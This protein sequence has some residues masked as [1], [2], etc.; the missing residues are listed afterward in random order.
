LKN[1]ENH[2]KVYL[3]Q[4]AFEYMLIYFTFQGDDLLGSYPKIFEEWFD[5][6]YADYKA[7]CLYYGLTIKKGYSDRPMIGESY[8]SKIGGI[9]EEDD[10]KHVK[11]V[12]FLKNEFCAT[13]EDGVMVGIY[14]YRPARDLIFRFGNSDK[15]SEFIEGIYAKALSLGMLTL[16]NIECY[17][18]FQQ[19]FELIRRKYDINFDNINFMLDTMAKTSN[20][21]YQLRKSDI[22]FGSGFPLLSDLRIRHN[23]EKDPSRYGL[24]CYARNSHYEIYDN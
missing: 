23:Q 12:T 15:A 21:F 1:Y 9:W 11:S 7:W 19:S 2:P 22:E 8:F 18:Y 4:V 20:T 10:E 14:P 6:T 5:M 17:Q 3:L 16:G 13:Y 24:Q